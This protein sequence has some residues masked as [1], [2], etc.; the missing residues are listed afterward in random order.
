M[1][2]TFQQG[3]LGRRVVNQIVSPLDN[4][5]DG[6][7]ACY[8]IGRLLSSYSG[9]LIRVRESGGDTEQD[10]GFLS[11]GSLDTTSLASFVGANSGFITTW[12]DQSGSGNDMLQATTTRQPRIVNAG[13]YDGSLVFNPTGTDDFLQTTATGS[14]SVN[15]KSIFR[16][17]TTRARN[18]DN[19]LF[20]YG[21]GAL[22]ATA[23]GANQIQCDDTSSTLDR[24]ISFLAT[25]ATGTGYY[26]VRYGGAL[27][28]PTP[29]SNGV[30]ILKGQTS[31]NTFYTYQVAGS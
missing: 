15:A 30:V 6:L 17:Y 29:T 11:D 24:M 3:Q 27:D 18:T 10:I 16:R 23:S 20:E 22:I 14:S 25:N 28:Q 4:Y 31:A 5:T 9:S 1:L 12:Y 7:W 21:D 26:D 13:S 2:F 19:I 8:G